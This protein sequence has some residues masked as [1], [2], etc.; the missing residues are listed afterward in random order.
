MTKMFHRQQNW[1]GIHCCCG[2]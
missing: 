2:E 1:C